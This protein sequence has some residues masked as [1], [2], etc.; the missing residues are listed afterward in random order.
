MNAWWQWEKDKEE[1]EY[2]QCWNDGSECEDEITVFSIWLSIYKLGMFKGANI[3]AR[4]IRY[5]PQYR[6]QQS[7]YTRAPYAIVSQ[8]YPEIAHMVSL[9]ISVPSSVFLLNIREVMLK[10]RAETNTLM[11]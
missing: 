2:F 1:K 3:F 6:A 7:Q 4:G 10:S 11:E 9:Q 5:L 8:G